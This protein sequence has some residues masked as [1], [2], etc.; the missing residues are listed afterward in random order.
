MNVLIIDTDKLD[1]ETTKAIYD[2]AVEI[3]GL[4]DW[5]VWPMGDVDLCWL[6]KI[7]N[8][9]DEMYKELEQKIS[10]WKEMAKVGENIDRKN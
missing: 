1:L 2:K 4:S 10:V 6:D 5:T 9:A 7:R 3:S 8:E